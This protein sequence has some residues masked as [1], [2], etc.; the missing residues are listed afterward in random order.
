MKQLGNRKSIYICCQILIFLLVSGI[1]K[2]HVQAQSTDL[3]ISQ[4]IEGSRNNKAVEFYNGTGRTIDLSAG[5]YVL[6]MYFNESTT[7]GRIVS[8]T[9][10]VANSDVYILSLSSAT[11]P[12]IISESNQQVTGTKF[13][14]GDDTLVL[15]KNGE[16]GTVV[17][18]IGQVGFNSEWGTGDTSTEDN[19]L[20][21]KATVCSGDTTPNDTF[22]PAIEWT[23]ATQDDTTGLGS[24]NANC[25]TSSTN[26]SSSPAPVFSNVA[27]PPD[28]YDLT[29]N[30]EGLGI[31]FDHRGWIHCGSDLNKC[32]NNI[33]QDLKMKLTAQAAVGWQF[34]NWQGDCSGTSKTVS[35]AMTNKYTCTAIFSKQ[36]EKVIP[37]KSS[38]TPS[39]LTIATVGNVLNQYG[40]YNLVS[41]TNPDYKS[42][43]QINN[44]KQESVTITTTLYSEQGEVLGKT[45]IISLQAQ[46]SVT[47]TMLELENLFGTTAWAG[48]AWLQLEALSDSLQ[49]VHTLQNP[50]ATLTHL[51]ATRQHTLYTL[52]N[53]NNAYGDELFIVFIN[54]SNQSLTNITGTVYT[55]DGQTVGKT[56]ALL[57]SNIA[58]KSV[59]TITAD[60]LEQRLGSSWSGRAWLQLSPLQPDIQ[61]MGLIK[62]K[63]GT[64]SNMSAVSANNTLHNLPGSLNQA[65]TFVRIVN[66]SDHSVQIRGSLFDVAGQVLSQPNTL[67]VENL[68]AKAIAGFQLPQLEEQ[69]GILPVNQSQLVVT[70]PTTGIIVT[71]ATRDS[72]GNIVNISGTE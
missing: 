59:E 68:P 54:T 12:E 2:Q 66:I 21:R 46:E 28:Y 31:V 51:S 3:I 67:L 61:V 56:N 8:L 15:W 4:Y 1:M 7:A 33:E 35:F 17:D 63:T 23:G 27:P 49:V 58:P 50:G 5:N 32:Q 48:N 57:L 69:F 25:S 6:A 65:Q 22:D 39:A 41:S 72:L 14:N 20:T 10:S 40:A 43:V 44:I 9:G 13:F 36:P 42:S 60:M 53:R 18:S 26:V 52:P 16:G 62:N 29:I 55:P 24:H 11:L 45:T 70:S 71:A 37:V 19:T 64:F 34:D 30:I 38:V 47:Y